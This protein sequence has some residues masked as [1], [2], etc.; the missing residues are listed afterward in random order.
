MIQSILQ[1]NTGHDQS[2]DKTTNGTH[3]S[4][5]WL[6]G[7]H[8]RDNGGGENRYQA[9][10]TAPNSPH[11][12]WTRPTED[13]GIVGG[14]NLSRDQ[15]LVTLSTLVHNTSQDWTNQVIMFGRL[16]YSPNVLSRGS[17]AL[18]GLCRP[19]NWRIHLRG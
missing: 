19:E 13:N 7:S 3:V 4:S 10:G 5:N 17:S 15:T 14:A 6:C 9:D 1:L 8:D 16:Y 2:K 11:I 18:F 12:L